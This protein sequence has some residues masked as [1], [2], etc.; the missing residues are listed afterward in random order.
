MRRFPNQQ[1]PKPKMPHLMFLSHFRVGNLASATPLTNLYFK[2]YMMLIQKCKWSS[3]LP[4]TI[5]FFRLIKE[6]RWAPGGDAKDDTEGLYIWL[7]DKDCKTI[8]GV[9][10]IQNGYSLQRICVAEEGKG[11]GRQFLKAIQEELLSVPMLPYAA[12]V[13]YEVVPFFRKCGY[14]RFAESTSEKAKKH[15]LSDDFENNGDTP[16]YHPDFEDRYTG[17]AMTRKDSKALRN[18]WLKKNEW[19]AMNILNWADWT[20]SV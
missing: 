6:G 11:L 8:L 1:V 10:Y 16:M 2:A 19:S 5:K 9:A 18:F 7:D 15:I 14:K 20:P 4:E 3:Q 13:G 17:V 12:S